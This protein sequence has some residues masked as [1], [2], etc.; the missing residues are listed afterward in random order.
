MASNCRPKGRRKS[1]ESLTADQIAA[2]ALDLLGREGLAAFSVR[3]LAKALGVS[4]AT[5]YWH[6]ET[7]NDVLMAAS[8]YAVR[9]LEL[10]DPKLP[11]QDWV[12]E[13]CRRYRRVVQRHRGV[14]GFIGSRL[15]LN[16][17]HGPEFVE[18]ILAALVSA[19]FD[20]R[21]I[22]DAF[23]VIVVA[24]VGFANQE[25]SPEPEESEQWVAER[26]AAINTVNRELTPLT[27]RFLPLLPNRVFI[28]RWEN[29]VKAPMEQS[30]E[31]YLDVVVGGLEM[32]LKGKFPQAQAQAASV[33][34]GR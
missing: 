4:P 11:W 33:R 31:F 9:G 17:V 7:R 10:P 30:F 2:A 8:A 15:A 28:L 29:G 21:D 1:A 3:N 18:G 34:P 23:N 12:R 22:I 19:G 25:L 6:W 16:A 27:A 26:R 20:E 24:M 32:R 14:T 13:L 5:I